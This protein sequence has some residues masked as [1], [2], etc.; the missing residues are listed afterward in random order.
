MKVY[1]YNYKSDIY[2]V[3]MFGNPS[4][5]RITE[6][7][8][9]SGSRHSELIGWGRKHLV[10]ELNIAL[11][12]IKNHIKLINPLELGM[13]IEVLT[14]PLPRVYPIITRYFLAR[15]IN[16]GK[17]IWEG[18]VQCAL[19]DMTERKVANGTKFGLSQPEGDEVIPEISSAC[20]RFDKKLR[21]ELLLSKPDFENLVSVRFSD[22]DYNGHVNS[23]RYLD[24]ITST[25]GQEIMSRYSIKN[26]DVEYIQEVSPDAMIDVKV[27]LKD[28]NIYAYGLIDDVVVFEGMIY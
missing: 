24:F 28:E 26:F 12:L 21:S 6:H 27:Y 14:W 19:M 10:N 16:T 22:L 11:V 23:A 9:I 25:V 20:V 8:L 17:I 3:D 4:F 13:D 15:D 5:S 7:M 1:K 18:E 2:D